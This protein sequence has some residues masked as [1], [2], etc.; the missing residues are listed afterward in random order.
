LWKFSG[1]ESREKGNFGSIDSRL[2]NFYKLRQTS[3]N[4]RQNRRE[5]VK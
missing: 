3:K 2:K 5:Q 1:H 4:L